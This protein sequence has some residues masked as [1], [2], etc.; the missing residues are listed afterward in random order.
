ML[1]GNQI[2]G[3][4]ALEV[5]QVEPETTNRPELQGTL[6]GSCRLRSQDM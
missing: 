1:D 3:D 2:S 5:R 4:G 6:R